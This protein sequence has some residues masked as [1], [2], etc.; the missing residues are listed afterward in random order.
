MQKNYALEAYKWQRLWYDN[1]H[2]NV[3]QNSLLPTSAVYYPER[4]YLFIGIK[5]DCQGIPATL[6]VIDVKKHRPGS[7]PP[8]TPYP[9]YELN[10]IPIYPTNQHFA[11]SLPESEFGENVQATNVETKWLPRPGTH[12]VSIS[13]SAT[14]STTSSHSTSASSSASSS[15]NSSSS[16]SSNSSSSHS[17][18][19]QSNQS[20]SNQSS[21]QSSQS[22][23]GNQAGGS[24]TQGSPS[25]SHSAPQ[26]PMGQFPPV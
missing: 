15:S 12:A 26:T 3:N 4:G 21:G 20:Q 18:Q 19:S 7:S 13:G 8:L 5:R 24:A 16:N 23:Q 6:N 1:P 11:R 2:G 10:E 25:S 17:N 22:H 9:N 14:S